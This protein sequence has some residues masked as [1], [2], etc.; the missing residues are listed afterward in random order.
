MNDLRREVLALSR[1]PRC[2]STFLHAWLHEVCDRN[3]ADLQNLLHDHGSADPRLQDLCDGLE[4]LS[5]D[6][7]TRSPQVVEWLNLMARSPV[8]DRFLLSCAAAL[9]TLDDLHRA[10]RALLQYTCC[11]VPEALAGFP[12]RILLP[13]AP[14]GPWCHPDVRHRILQRKG[15]DHRTTTRGLLQLWW[16]VVP[17][18]R[19]PTPSWERLPEHVDRVLRSRLP[20]PTFALASPFVGL[21]FQVRGDPSRKRSDKGTPY[22]FQGLHPEDREAATRELERLL[23]RCRERKVDVLVLPELAMDPF[24]EK[25][26]ANLLSTGNPTR[27]PALVIAG[28]AHVQEAFRPRGPGGGVGHG[29]DGASWNRCLVLDARGDEVWRH[30]KCKGF[31]IPA[32][33]ARNLPAPFLEDWNLDSDGGFEDIHVGTQVRI[34]D[35]SL[36]RMAALICLDYCGHTLRDLLISAGVNLVWVPAMTTSMGA[37]ADRARELGTAVQ[38]ASFVSNSGWILNRMG[39]DSVS[40]GL[41]YLPYPGALHTWSPRQQEEGMVVFTIRQLIPST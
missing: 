19:Q 22:L 36:G 10:D 13:P 30:V 12:P 9:M 17:A 5:R 27:H 32:E 31:R 28:S 39:L 23:L 11:P 14:E 21:R 2:S 29:E 37:F 15:E 8:R 34:L 7:H 18:S 3:L 6:V 1:A 4:A 40:S 20:N 16:H 26:L 33:E 41:A 24:L 35:G 38:A 25:A